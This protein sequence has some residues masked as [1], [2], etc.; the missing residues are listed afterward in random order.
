M[1]KKELTITPQQVEEWKKQHGD[2]F[3]LD[4]DG[5][6]CYLK[7]PSRKVISMATTIGQNDPVKFS[8][9]MMNNC[10]LGGDEI[11]RTDDE[12]FLSAAGKLAELIQLK[13]AELKKL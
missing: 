8:E 11:I 13:E 9:L 10:W 7:K 5:H 4:V 1:D 2:I 6:T 3:Q 12:L